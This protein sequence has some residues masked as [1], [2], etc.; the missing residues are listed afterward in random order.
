MIDDLGT[1]NAT[2]W[3]QEKLY[4]I[5]NYRYVNRLPTVVTTNQPLEEI[6]G[7][8]HSR[9]RD[10]ELVDPGQDQHV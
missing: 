5:F 1:Q 3:A 2:P 9:L 10:P 7:R 6:E 4:Q 8:I